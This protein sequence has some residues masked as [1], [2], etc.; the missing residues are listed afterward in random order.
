MIILDTNVISE[1]MRPIPARAVEAWLERHGQEELSTTVMCQAEILA[2]IAL[3][4]AGRRREELQRRADWI[5]AHVFA[6][7]ILAFDGEV[8]PHFA[9]IIA[10]RQ[11]AGRPIGLADAIIG[12]IARRRQAP[13][14]TRNVADF[15]GCGIELHDPWRGD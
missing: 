13:L 9:D 12:A 2:G 1:L 15:E 8:A 4:P 14:V 11:R 7:K 6:E 10:H 3:L 5:F